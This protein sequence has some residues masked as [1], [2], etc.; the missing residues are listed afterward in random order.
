MTI[1]DTAFTLYP[2]RTPL[3]I[4][5]PHVGTELPAELAARMA[6]RAQ[7]VEDTDWHLERLYRFARAMGAG[8]LVPRYSRYVVD[9][10]R[11]PQNTPMYAGANNTELCPTRFFTGDP[12]YRAGRAP[13]DFVFD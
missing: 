6:D 4:S 8:L 9:L 7:A 10:N 3:L 2:G 12:L 1:N 11:P 5:L 13:D